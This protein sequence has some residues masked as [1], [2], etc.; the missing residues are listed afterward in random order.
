MLES[1]EYSNLFLA[2]LLVIT[3]PVLTRQPVL[4][5]RH[6]QRVQLITETTDMASTTALHF[7]I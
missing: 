1:A 5:H 3:G 4:V 2:I 6:I 7:R